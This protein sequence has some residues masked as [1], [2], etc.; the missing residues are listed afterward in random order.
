LL[1]STARRDPASRP[2]EALRELSLAHLDLHRSARALHL[3]KNN[4]ALGFF[5][6]MTFSVWLLSH[7]EG[8]RCTHSSTIAISHV[9]SLPSSFDD[10]FGKGLCLL[11][12]LFPLASPC[13]ISEATSTPTT[14]QALCAARTL[15]L[16]VSSCV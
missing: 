9:Y 3:P 11:G 12:S 8:C 16:C 1:T 2:L 14:D 15:V 4:I 10:F 5:C 6:Q 7:V 13:L